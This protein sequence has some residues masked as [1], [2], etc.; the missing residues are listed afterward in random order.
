MLRYIE[1]R[2]IPKVIFR[3][4]ESVNFLFLEVKLTNTRQ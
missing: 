4:Q 1:F 3:Y 2:K